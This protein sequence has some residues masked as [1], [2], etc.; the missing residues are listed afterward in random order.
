MTGLVLNMGLDAYQGTDNAGK[1]RFSKPWCAVGDW[2][3]FAKW[4]GS[5]IQIKQTKFRLLNDDE[6]FAVVSDPSMVLRA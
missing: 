5:R 3:M 4:A 6:V 1:P 2:V